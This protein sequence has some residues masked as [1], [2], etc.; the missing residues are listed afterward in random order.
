MEYLELCTLGD[1]LVRGAVSHPD[2][3][4][5]V[6]TEGRRTYAEL[7]ERSQR[8]ARGLIHLGIE[9]GDRV[10]MLM[11]NS[12][13]FLEV[14]FACAL[15]GAIAVPINSRFRSV[16]LQHV[17]PDAG[18]RVLFLS[19]LV[20]D[21]VSYID[22]IAE[23]FPAIAAHG[24]ADDLASPLQLSDAPALGHVIVLGE[25]RRP[26][27]VP[28]A[29]FEEAMRAVT[30][31]EVERRR[32]RVRLRDQAVIFY[33]SGT[34]AL[35]KGCALSHEAMVRQGV[36]TADRL[37]YRDGDVMFSPLPM[38]HTGCTQV[39]LG[40]LHRSGTYLSMT[41][42]DAEEGLR[43]IER[44]RATMLFPAFSAIT[45]ALMDAPSYTP[46]LFRDVRVLFHIATSDQLRLLQERLPHTTVVTAFGMTEFAGSVTMADPGD[47]LERRVVQGRPLPGNEVEIHGLVSG[48]PTPL[49][50]EG[51]IVARGPV[52]FSGY[53]GDPE[54]TAASF[55]EGG[56]YRTGDLGILDEDGLLHFRGR[57]KDMLKIGGENVGTVE[58]ES[59]LETHPAV[60]IANVVGVPDGRLGE[61]AAAFIELRAGASATEAE[62]I[63]HCR[64]RIASFKVPRYVRFVTEWPMSATKIRKVDLRTSIAQEL[65]VTVE[66]PTTTD[67]PPS[68]AAP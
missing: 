50:E 22:R 47:P 14:E 59:Y 31:E 67:P 4:A 58:I 45:D 29:A 19:D 13:T 48:Q 36:A 46:E 25:T 17:V 63:D 44:E 65:G 57:L 61:V 37:G 15:I 41:H 43:L 30:V 23:T 9:R 60:A 8:I 55:A 53:H 34:T 35:P 3:D 68:K 18:I 21:E 20:E 1:L 32:A 27:F 52:L 66:V 51:E 40:V 5:L 33:T 64:G 10:G 26:G 28:R 11:P 24:D 56:W 16:E 7:L 54:R 42:F 6:L 38:F 2:R 49:G 12:L 39:L 62:I